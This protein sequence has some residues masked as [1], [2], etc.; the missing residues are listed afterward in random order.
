MNP[1]SNGPNTKRRA[2]L[3]GSLAAP[4]VLTVSS[5]TAAMVTSHMKCAGN[6][7]QPT[8]GELKNLFFKSDEQLTA[9]DTWLRTPI[10]VEQFSHGNLVAWFYKDPKLGYIN[11]ADLQVMANDGS[12]NAASK[13][14]GNGSSN[15]WR[16]VDLVAPQDR[17]ALVWVDKTSGAPHHLIQVQRP[18]SGY[19]LTTESCNASVNPTIKR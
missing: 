3:R 17:W 4:V 9:A 13:G 16:K 2:I 18:T 10:K 15:G 14:L 8:D 19:Q 12:S 1:T 5:P 6:V 11:I 7:R